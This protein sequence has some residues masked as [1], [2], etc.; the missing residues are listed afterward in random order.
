M[1]YFVKLLV[2]SGACLMFAGCGTPPVKYSGYL[3]D[4]SE[5]KPV[6]DDKGELRR[7]INPNLKKGEYTKLLVDPII[8]YPEPKPTKQVSEETF[9][10]IRTYTNQALVRELGKTFILVKKAGPGV[11]RLS[12][13]ITG[14]ATHEEA[15]E[16]YQYIP[17]ALLVAGAKSAAGGRAEVAS[18]V[19]ESKLVD[20]VTN[21]KLGI[22][23]RQAPAPK[24]LKN[25]DEKLTLN[26]MKPM[27]DAKAKD[28]EELLVS[29][30]RKP[31]AF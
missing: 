24:L 3:G 10:Q 19:L 7:W 22:A 1:Q 6:K 2:I 12:V 28:A 27:I 5:L 31:E 20:S 13:A 30:L 11:A 18:M 4:Y 26:I 9:Q 14:V 15:L 17:I 25:E 23:V 8:F 21:E 29:I 16:A